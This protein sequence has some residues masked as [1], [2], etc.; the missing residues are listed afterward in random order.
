MN[1][2]GELWGL[3]SCLLVHLDWV[4]YVNQVLSSLLFP[5]SAGPI[6]VCVFLI[7]N[8][9]LFLPLIQVR[10]ICLSSL[11]FLLPISLINPLVQVKLYFSAIL[12][13]TQ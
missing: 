8:L 12:T 11:E 13:P 6:L 10:V 7:P 1:Q 9:L 5:Q 2:I 4:L 3:G